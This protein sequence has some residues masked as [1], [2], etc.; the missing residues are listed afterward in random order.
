MRLVWC[1]LNNHR[2]ADW[3]CSSSRGS[4][5]FLF[6]RWTVNQVIVKAIC[7]VCACTPYCMSECVFLPRS[8]RD[9][10]LLHRSEW[11]GCVPCLDPIWAGVSEFSQWRIVRTIKIHPWMNG[12]VEVAVFSTTEAKWNSSGGNVK[13]CDT[14]HPPR[15]LR[16]LY[17]MCM[18]FSYS[19]LSGNSI[20][21]EYRNQDFNF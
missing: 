21:D 16:L 14:A 11:M 6:V 20:R 13:H 7:C 5:I 17:R 15:C 8:I 2:W 4:K 12:W 10:K 9:S 18:L 3:C 1:R 19:P